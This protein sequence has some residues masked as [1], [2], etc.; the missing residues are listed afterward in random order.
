MIVASKAARPDLRAADL[1]QPGQARTGHL[2][3]RRITLQVSSHARHRRPRQH[4]SPTAPGR[5]AARL[6]VGGH[7]GAPPAVA[8]PAP[9]GVRRRAGAEH[10]VRRRRHGLR[11]SADH[12]AGHQRRLRPT[13]ARHRVLA[14]AMQAGHREVVADGRPPPGR[15]GRLAGPPVL[16]GPR[17]PEASTAQRPRDLD[18][19]AQGRGRQD[20]AGGQPR[21]RADRQGRPPGVPGRPRPGV[22]RRRDHPAAVPGAHDRST[23]SAPRSDLDFAVLKLAAHPLPGLPQGAGGA[24]PPGRP[25]TD[26]PAADRDRSCAPCG[27]CSTTSWSTPRRPS[28]SRRCRPSTRPTSAARRDARRAHAEER[29]GGRSTRSTCSTSAA[30][31]ATWCSTGPTTRSGSTPDKVE[32]T[33]G[34]TIA[35]ADPHV[36]RHRRTRPTPASRSSRASPNHPSSQP[37]ATS[38]ALLAGEPDAAGDDPGRHADTDND[39]FAK[40]F[41]ITRRHREQSRRTTRRGPQADR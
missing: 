2:D 37:S 4:H 18:L 32:T 17:G 40:L 26:Q 12:P 7:H 14:R 25:R 24:E 35:V 8:G 10:L 36:H 34:M 27:P 38:S 22:R 1:Q 11:G 30:A 33:L 16:P 3:P 19:L 28:T 31:T 21:P 39:R 9:R 20:H 29:Q 6:P 15:R 41:R 5:T 23:R 13:R